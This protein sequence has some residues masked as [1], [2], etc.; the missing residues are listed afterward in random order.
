MSAFCAILLLVISTLLS[1]LLW[2]KQQEINR[3]RVQNQHLNSELTLVLEK[4][5]AIDSSD[6]SADGLLEK[7]VRGLVALGV[8]GLVL[9]VGTAV[10]GYAGA[11]AITTA[12][13]AMGGPGGMI[14]GIGVLILVG[15]IS[16]AL[17]K[18]GLPKIAKPV[19][20]GLISAG[21]TPAD[22]REKVSNYPKWA[23]SREI[24]VEIYETLDNYQRN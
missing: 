12:L 17:T 10:S 19:I 7:V 24:R 1:V 11:A 22:I 4:L 18:W 14:G 20:S 2:R 3:L 23:M 16:R 15:L 5:A 8:P 13:A 21:S 6:L 9:L